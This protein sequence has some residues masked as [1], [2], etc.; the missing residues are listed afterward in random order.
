MTPLSSPLLLSV[1]TSTIAVTVVTRELVHP[2]R[3]LHRPEEHLRE[4][5]A[6][7]IL[8]ER[9]AWRGGQH[10]NPLVFMRKLKSR[11]CV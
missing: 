4:V 1:I 9:A 3:R 2:T 10:Y 8:V 11:R 6:Q 7:R 5:S